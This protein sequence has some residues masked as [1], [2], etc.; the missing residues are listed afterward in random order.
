MDIKLNIEDKDIVKEEEIE[1]QDHHLVHLVI[2]HQY[3]QLNRLH[4]EA[5]DN[6]GEVGQEQIGKEVALEI[7]KQ[8]P[9]VDHLG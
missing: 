8:D 5:K 6:L 2:F 1:V 4:L 7:D 9:E 3:L